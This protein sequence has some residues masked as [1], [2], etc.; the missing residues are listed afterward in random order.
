MKKFFGIILL[1]VGF[2]CLPKVF[3]PSSPETIGG[4]IGISLVTFL[5]AFFL[6]RSKKNDSDNTK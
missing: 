2:I 5:P 3:A 1:I 4:L 6:L